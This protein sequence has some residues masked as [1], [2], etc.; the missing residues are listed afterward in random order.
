MYVPI[1]RYGASR[2]CTAPGSTW[3]QS[4]SCGWMHMIARRKANVSI[5]S[6]NADLTRAYVKSYARQR[7]EQFRSWLAEEPVAS[8][9]WASPTASSAG[10][11]DASMLAPQ[12]VMPGPD[13]LTSTFS[14]ERYRAAVGQAID[15][16]HAGDIF[17]VNL[18]QRLLF[19]AA[20]GALSLYFRL[21]QRNPATFAAWFDLG[22]GEQRDD[23]LR[24]ALRST[25]DRLKGNL[26]PDMDG[27]AWGKLHTINF[28][29]VLG[30]LKLLASTF[31]RGPYPIGGDLTTVW[32]AIHRSY[33]ERRND[34]PALPLHRGPVGPAQLGRQP[35][36]G[37]AGPAG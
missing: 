9:P 33:R 11:L 35:G 36:A 15:Y 23:V 22:H 31:S 20:T 32:A 13:G 3:Y 1:T 26:G 37:P 14:A 29:H 10:R 19:P 2:N 8:E 24:L 7:I 6:A 34:W 27:W 30:S 17:Q 18:A 16:I 12:F 21:R 28:G 5:E 4:Y 25:I